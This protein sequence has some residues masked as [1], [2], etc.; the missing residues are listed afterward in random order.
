MQSPS[1]LRFK[2]TSL[3]SLTTYCTEEQIKVA[4]EC[5]AEL[6]EDIFRM[7]DNTCISIDDKTYLIPTTQQMI[8][9]LRGKGITVLVVTYNHCKN[10]KFA[11]YG[12]GDTVYDSD[13]FDSYEKAESE[14]ITKALSLLSLCIYNQKGIEI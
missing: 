3:L 10:F 6:Y 2:D 12:F 5:G 1:Y 11:I 13:T 8:K 4:H 7:G 14:G 9:W